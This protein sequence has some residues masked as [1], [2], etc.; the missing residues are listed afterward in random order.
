MTTQEIAK[1]LVDIYEGEPWFGESLQ[2]KL[3]NVSAEHAYMQLVHNKHSIAEILSHMEFWRKSFISQL[4]GDNAESFSGDS[5]DN[6]PSVENLKKRGWENQLSSFHDT[7][8]LL[9]GLLKSNTKPLSDDLINNLNGMVDH[10]VYHMG[11]IGIVKSL[12]NGT[13]K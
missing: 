2:A 11:Q 3:K 4:K 5:P 1:R 13:T 9:V 8:K 10:D 7:Q 6:W 12:I